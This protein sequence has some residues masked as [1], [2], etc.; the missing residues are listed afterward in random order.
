M[1][2]VL[3]AQ[4]AGVPEAVDAVEADASLDERQRQ[5][6][7]AA[8]GSLHSLY[9]QVTGARARYVLRDADQTCY[10]V[11]GLAGVRLFELLDG[12][13]TPAELQAALRQRW[14][15]DFSLDKL[16]QFIDMCAHNRLIETGTWVAGPQREAA[17]MRERLGLYGAP[18][19]ADGLLDWLQGHRRW[20]LNPATKTLALLLMLS[21]VVHLFMIPPGGGLLAPL[22]Q[23]TFT[24][25]DVIFVLLPAVLLVEMSLHELAHALACRAMGARTRGFGIGLMWGVLPIV[26]TDTTDAYTIPSRYR[27]MFV[28]FAGPM[29]NIMSF[30]LSMAVYPLLEPGGWPARVVLAYSG[31]S[32][33]LFL[34]SLNPFL[35]RMDGYWIMADWLEQPN[36]RRHAF[37]YLLGGWTQ[38]SR[39]AEAQGMAAPL[40]RTAARRAQYIAYAVVAL[41]W[42]TTY[43]AVMVREFWLVTQQIVRHFGIEI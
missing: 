32:L 26:Y 41:G 5:R 14:Q 10:L 21:A 16:C 29:V 22:K 7:R 31:L 13:R 20:W 27:R 4:S 36:L 11:T 37:R 42:T 24:M 15:L 18:L 8:A 3:P 34:V 2:A 39:D 23:L 19:S 17:T 30:G 28:S 6:P 25:A 33:S 43:I 12:E 38:R 1:S 9:G 40:A 35:V